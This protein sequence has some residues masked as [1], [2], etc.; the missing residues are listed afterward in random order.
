MEQQTA[1]T[2]VLRQSRE[3]GGPAVA[4]LGDWSDR[5]LSPCLQPVLATTEA[6]ISS[7]KAI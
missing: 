2:S 4:H 3:T 7:S 6:M 5:E 1:V